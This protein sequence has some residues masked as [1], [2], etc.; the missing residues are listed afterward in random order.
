MA[1]TGYRIDYIIRNIDEELSDI[2]TIHQRVFPKNILAV[3]KTK[4][5]II[6]KVSN[7]SEILD[8]M[9]IQKAKEKI[10]YIEKYG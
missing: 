4:E 1:K 5:K 10:G 8:G 3:W 6:V 9:T 7:Y 2:L